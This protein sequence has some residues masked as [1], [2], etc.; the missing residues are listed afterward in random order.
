MA[1]GRLVMKDLGPGNCPTFSPAAD[2]VIFLLNPN[3]VPG[4]EV[5][6]YVMQ[7]D[8]SDRRFLGGYGRPRWSPGGHQFLLISFTNPCEVTL[9][10]DRPNTKSGVLK[11]PD[12]K[13]FSIPS[14]AGEGTI[15]AAI[16]A[17]AGDTIALIDVTDPDEA[18]V[19]E[20]LWKKSNGPDLKPYEP[21]YRRR[22]A[23]AFSW[24]ETPK[25]MALYSL[26]PGKPAQPK[27]LEPGPTDNLTRDLSYSPDGRFLLFSSNR[28]DR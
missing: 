13:I 22:P 6:V 8:G 19:K 25:G 23:V 27:R 11:S 26:E 4:A 16:G 3:Q 24:V 17:E 15:I 12:Q 2:R 1:G 5:G 10:D 28:P 20:V 7:A 21:I 18:K 14:W 9:I